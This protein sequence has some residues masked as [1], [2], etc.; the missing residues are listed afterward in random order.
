VSVDPIEFRSIIGHFATGVTVITTAAGQE[1]QGMTANAVA[2]LSLDPVM[3]LICV[4]KSTHTHRL[5]EAGGVFTVNIL[6][7]HQ[8]DVSRTFARRAEPEAGSLRGVPFVFGKTG[9]PRLEDCLAF[10]ECRISNALD[11]GDHTIFLGEVVAEGIVND[12]K[13]LMFFRGKYRSLTDET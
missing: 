12:V 2:S 9:S 3:V 11:G 13:P 6:G 5:L 4:E 7:E 8:E 10:L 1:L